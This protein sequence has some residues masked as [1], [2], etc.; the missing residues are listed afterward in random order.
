MTVLTARRILVEGV[1]QGV[2]FRP[3]VYGLATRRGLRGWVR[4]T[5]SGVEIEVEGPPEVVDA[6]VDELSA[7]R[8][9]LA[10]IDRLREEELEPRGRGGF[11]IQHSLDGSGFQPVSPDVGTCPDCLSEVMDPADRRFGYPFTNCTHCGPRFTIIRAVP[12]DRPNTTMAGFVMCLRCR[13][14]YEDPRD[15]RFHAQPNACAECGPRLSLLDAGGAPLPGDPLEETRRLLSAGR[16]VAIK[17]IGGFHLACDATDDAA[18][19]RLRE[20]KG[21]EAKPLALMAADLAAAESRCEISP[22]ERKLLG[23]PARPIV[24]LRERPASGIAP[25]VAPGLGWLGVM[26]P[27]APLHHLLLRGDATGSPALVMTSGN[28]S[29]EPIATENDDAL[30]R[31]ST[32]ADAFL[33]HDRPIQVRCDDSVTRVAGSGELPM[34]RSRGY[35]PFPVRLSSEGPAVLA[36]GAD[37]KN[38]VCLTRGPYAF[39]SPHIGD[40]EGHDTYLSY[41]GMVERMAE[42]FRVR[43]EAVAHDLHPDYLSTRHALSLAPAV[44]RVAVQHH[45][46]H[47]A[48]CMAE[49]GLSGPVIGVAF[50]GT[51]YGTDGAIW[52]GEFLVADYASFERAAHWGYVPMPGGDRAAREPYRMALAHLLRAFGDWDPRWLPVQAASETERRMIRWQIERDVNAPLTSSVGRLFDA[53]ASLV[54]V[55]HRARYE[56]QAAMELEALADG[57]TADGPYPLTIA[58]DAPLVIEPGPIVAAVVRDRAAGTPPPVIA[59]RFH[60]TVAQAVVQV[61]GRLRRTTGLGRV[62]LSGGVFQNVTLLTATCRGLGAT[63][64]EVATHHLVPPND[65]GLALGQAAVARARLAR[66]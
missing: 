39:M 51:G 31:L 55:R 52:G 12:Y 46:A 34:R 47:V 27:Y 8:P 9:P 35:A 50:D 21:R 54:G 19:R 61:C 36:L 28:R 49:H 56:A 14:E 64:F 15:R 30:R 40:L 58:G 22:E 23:S 66:R 57:V 62:V 24:L 53:V 16:I 4:N 3:F 11:E 20:R 48:A 6:F 33:L 32:V 7:E 59:A 1:V 65:G 2:G 17:G 13:A 44:P 29:E 37:L 63:G 41:V 45:H 60:A 42:L 26:L 25:S 10:H 5:A 43:P 18:V 38:T